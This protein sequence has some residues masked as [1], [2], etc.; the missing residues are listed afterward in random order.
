R[1]ALNVFNKNK[2][3]VRS[4][5]ESDGRLLFEGWLLFEGRLLFGG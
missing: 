1:N 5:N 2:F 4:K 3:E